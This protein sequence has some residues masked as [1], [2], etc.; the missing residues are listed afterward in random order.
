M[1]REMEE[2]KPCVSINDL[3]NIFKVFRINA[4]EFMFI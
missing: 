4:F 2:I 1:E 3:I